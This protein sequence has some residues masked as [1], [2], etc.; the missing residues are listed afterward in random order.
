MAA[1]L[2]MFLSC[3]DGSEYRQAVAVLVDVSGTYAD[4]KGEVARIVKREVL[5]SL[6]PGDSLLL[7]RIDSQSYDK[8][9]VLSLT[10]L[11][12]R[13][14]QANAQ[15]LAVAKQLDEFVASDA[16]SQYTDI[17]GAMMLAAEYLREI[18][19]GSRVILCFSDMAADLP[20]G[21]KRELGPAEFAD[22]QVVAMNVKRLQSDGEDPQRFRS[23]LEQWEKTVVAHGA[24]GWQTF[25]DA[26]KLG[27]YL[28]A[29]R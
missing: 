13:P 24:A 6:V 7:V 14:S 25:M 12:A 2:C 18:P 27:G 23:R 28:A 22:I 9:N 26:G 29:V 15:K 1:L 19:A 16:R 5:P 10:T 21:S 11:D 3:S 8:E 17:P 20:R 4:E